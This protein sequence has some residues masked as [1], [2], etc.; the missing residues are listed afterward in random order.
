MN[1]NSY[2]QSEDSF[3]IGFSYG[4]G[5]DIAIMNKG[6]VFYPLETCYAHARWL[7]LF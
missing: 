3:S 7:M 2:F 6:G 4:T 1:F 5:N